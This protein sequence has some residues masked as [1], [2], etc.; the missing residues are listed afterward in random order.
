MNDSNKMN[1]LKLKLNRIFGAYLEQ[2]TLEERQKM[3]SNLRSPLPFIARLK[4]LI[5]KGKI[6]PVGDDYCLP[7]G[8]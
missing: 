7:G 6:R 5:R 8:Q 2:I 1:T 3:L 4:G